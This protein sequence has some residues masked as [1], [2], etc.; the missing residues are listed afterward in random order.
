MGT[1]FQ[2]IKPNV[3]RIIFFVVLVAFSSLLY[4]CS[5]SSKPVTDIN[6]SELTI[7]PGTSDKCTLIVT[8]NR[9]KD[10]EVSGFT[11]AAYNDGGEKVGDSEIITSPNPG[12]Q[13]IR[14]DYEKTFY[15]KSFG[16]S[17]LRPSN[18]SKISFSISGKFIGGS[19]EHYYYDIILPKGDLTTSGP[20][21]VTYFD[22]N[23]YLTGEV[24]NTG[25]TDIG[26]ANVAVKIYSDSSKTN[27]TYTSPPEDLDLLTGLD[28]GETADFSVDCGTYKPVYYDII[29]DWSNE[30]IE[31]TF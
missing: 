3:Q 6:I 9:G 5:P 19:S 17:L 8:N 24:K 11:A 13:T 14:G 10:F 4:G 22:G 23:Y 12:S 25:R 1:S 29:F 30:T 27:L 2:S 31:M 15:F 16:V 26:N 20:V 21:N 18:V 28:Q 7:Y